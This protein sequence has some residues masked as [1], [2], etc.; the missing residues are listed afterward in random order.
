[1]KPIKLILLVSLLG[2]GLLSKL[3]AAYTEIYRPQYHF[4]PISGWVGDPDGLVRYN[5]IY[6]LFWWGHA[7]SSDLVYWSQLP[8]PM[9]GGDGSF[10]YYS[11]SVAVDKQN[12]IMV[13][14]PVK[15]LVRTFEPAK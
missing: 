8:Y 13:L 6:H 10:T 3:E 15:K 1:M 5:N 11:G 12:R 7:V 9:N 2:F 4:S 14:D